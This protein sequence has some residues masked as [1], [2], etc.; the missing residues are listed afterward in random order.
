M[1]KNPKNQ[2][3]SADTYQRML[4]CQPGDAFHEMFSF[5]VRVRSLLNNKIAVTEHYGTGPIKEKRFFDSAENF[6]HHYS[7]KS[8]KN[9]SFLRWAPTGFRYAGDV[10]C[11]CEPINLLTYGCQCV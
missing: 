9:K 11:I 3:S 7:Y 5:V 6:A 2:P 10:E 4:N 1:I 8:M